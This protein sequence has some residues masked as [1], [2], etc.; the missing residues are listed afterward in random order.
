MRMGGNIPKQFMEM[1][2]KAVLHVSMEKFITA[3][4]GIRIFAVLPEDHVGYWKH[5]C[6]EHNFTYP[7]TIVRGGITRFHSVKN[8]I[9]RIDGEALVAVHDGV[10]PLV[11][12]E[13]ITHLFATAEDKGSAVPFV[14]V[15]DTAKMLAET[16][17]PGIYAPVSGVS[18]DR[19]K[20]FCVQTPQIFGADI[21]KHA[22][23]QAYDTSFTDDASVVEKDGGSV[24]YV[25]GE[26]TNIKL[27]TP[28]DMMFVKALMP[29]LR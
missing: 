3:C 15:V 17:D 18:V 24:C 29:F 13:M 21:L 6:F 14:P 16:S 11:S 12:V 19:K 2:G 1:D 23:M 26:R 28:E 27:T 8:A 7:Q 4:P 10:R 9:S 5:Y 22:Y 20:I 25:R